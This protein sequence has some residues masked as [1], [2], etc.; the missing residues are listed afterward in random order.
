MKYNLKD[1]SQAKE[2]FNY[3]TKLTTQESVCEVKK[4]NPNRS[5]KQ[6]AYLHLIIGYF[7]AHFG[8]TM[9]EA[10]QIY[11]EV[12]SDLYFYT[13]KGRAFIRSSAD[14][15]TDEMTKSIDRFREK[16]AEHGLPLP[17][18]EDKEMLIYMENEIERNKSYL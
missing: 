3:L 2:A 12:S 1:S 13:K 9:E 4:V 17:A 5:L 8:Y 7:G 18:P 16:S 15:S 10:K 6:N 11:K 14:L